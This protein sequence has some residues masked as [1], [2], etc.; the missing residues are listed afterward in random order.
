MPEPRGTVSDRRSVLSPRRPCR[1][2]TRRLA[3]GERV[4]QLRPVR[5]L[6]GERYPAHPAA[7]WAPGMHRSALS[8]TYAGGYESW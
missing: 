1:P 3:G 2:T 7:C 8:L 6:S 4:P 5:R